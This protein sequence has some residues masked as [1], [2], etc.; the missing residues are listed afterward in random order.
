MHPLVRL[1]AASAAPLAEL[2]RAT[3]TDTY[4]GMGYYT[5]ELVADYTAQSFAPERVAKELDDPGTSFFGVLVGDAI[6]AYV[7]VVDREPP[8]CVKPLRALY[9]ERLYV[10]RQYQR[11]GFGRRLLDAAFAEARARGLSHLWLSTWEE[12]KAAVAYYH[13]RGFTQAGEWPWIFESRGVRYV[14]RD[15]LFTIPVPY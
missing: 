7:K 2:A 11:V 14:D 3:F 9:V 13:A 10:A 6:A 5:R 4:V 15:L 1:D 12:N 8:D